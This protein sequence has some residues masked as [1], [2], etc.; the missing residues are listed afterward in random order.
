M[1]IT[2]TT[3]PSLN[4][5]L[6]GNNLVEYDHVV[7]SPLTFSPTDLTVAG[8]VRLTSSVNTDADVVTGTVTINASTGTVTFIIANLDIHHKTTLSAAQITAVTGYI[9]SAQDSIEAGLVTI[10]VVAGTQ[11]TG[12]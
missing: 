3:P 12:T 5:I 2:L 7:L 6:G 8:T 11:S 10:G 9:S 4:N 1:S